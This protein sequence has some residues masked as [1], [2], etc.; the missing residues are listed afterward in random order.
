MDHST[1]MFLLMSS[2]FM[3]YLLNFLDY[4]L[5][6]YSVHIHYT[7]VYHSYFSVLLRFVLFILVLR[8]MYPLFLFF[9]D[10]LYVML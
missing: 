8:V 5:H 10:F 4:K 1:F 9:H 3:L 6:Q 2:I 7:T